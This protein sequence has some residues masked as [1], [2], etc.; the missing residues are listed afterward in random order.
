MTRLVMVWLAALAA[1][2]APGAHAAGIDDKALANE[3]DGTN[4]ASYGRSFSENHYSPL[5]QI[6]DRNISGLGLVWSYDLPIV[7]NTFTAPLAVDGVLYFAT[8]YSV[9]RA[10]D[11]RTGKLLWEYDPEVYRV[12]GHK[13]RGG[14]GIRGIAF[15]QGKVY[16]GTHD[17]RLISLDA[18]TGRV[19]WS[20]ETVGRDDGRYV[21]GP[22]WVFKGK[23]LIGFGGGDFDPVRGYVTA[24]DAQTGRQ[25]WR[26]YTVPGNPKDGFEDEAMAMAAKTW[27]GE[28]WRFGGAGGTVWS[29]MAYDPVYNRVY[30]GTGNGSPWNQKIRS[31]GG[32][33]NLFLCSIV[34][35]DADTGKYVWHYQ[36]NPGETW[37]Y[38]AAMDIEL[39]DLTID[40]KR[41]PVLMHAPKNGFFYVIDRHE[42]KLI[43]AGKF[44]PMNW[45]ERVDLATGRPIEVPEARFPDGKAFV[46]YP[47]AIGAHGPQA[48]S[49]SP[50]TGLSYIPTS[51][52]AA[53]YVDPPG[54]L[55]D[56]K[57]RAAMSVNSGLG[58][59]PPGT[60]VPPASSYLQAFDPV[61]QRTVWKVPLVGPVNGA[62]ASTAGNLVFQGQVTGEFSAYAADDGRKVWSFD[63]QGGIESQPITYLVD[64][65]QYV[66]VIAGWRGMGS[67]SGVNP[68]WDYYT[69]KRRVLTF[70]LG[71]KES[72][73]AADKTVRPIVDDPAFVVDPAKVLVGQATFG[74]CVLCHG[75]RVVSGGTAPDLRKSMVP[76]SKDAITSVVRDG[77]LTPR[78]MPRFEE[79]TD[80]QIEGLQ[81]YIRQRARESMTPAN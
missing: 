17:G 71:G 42:Q 43:S 8:G 7:S 11:A 78:G 5:R 32:G 56:W 24:Y 62:V 1:T 39:A 81:H 51:E 68:E 80:E 47:A 9:V 15:W 18:K 79:F 46:M 35:L 2:L 55:A 10:L 73:P 21:T 13:M 54:N 77:A 12:A 59:P 37:D 65:R 22:P 76:L 48:M 20:V 66:T 3:A 40:G 58:P 64:G 16:T 38:N 6:N 61:R 27:S 74:R 25:L 41:R 72:L 44:A 28:W 53:V 50:A 49:Y 36:V 26:F 67:S 14:W 75:G 60:V 31:P 57:P 33:D 69:Q 52:Y 30:L 63:G 45:A 4:W 23:V 34:A 19:I 70:A 29:A